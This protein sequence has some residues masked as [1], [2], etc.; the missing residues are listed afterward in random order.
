MDAAIIKEHLEELGK[1]IRNRRI[2]QGLTQTKLAMMIGNGQSYIYRVEA[3]KIGVGIDILMKIA[4][5]LDIEV[6]DLI[7]F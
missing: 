7:T 5:A 3:G 6:R 2:A 1:Q 4:D